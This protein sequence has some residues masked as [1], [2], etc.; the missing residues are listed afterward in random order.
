[1]EAAGA[2]RV[3]YLLHEGLRSRGHDAELWFLYFKRPAYSGKP[4]VRV[5]SN[6]RPSLASYLLLAIK[7]FVWIWNSK[8]DVIITHTHYAN[9]LGQLLGALAGVKTR[10]AVQHSILRK[11]PTFSR[12]ADWLLGTVGVYT[13]QIAVSHSVADSMSAY[14]ERYKRIVHTIYNGIALGENGCPNG[15]PLPNLPVGH[16]RILHVGRLS[17]EKNHE[18]LLKSLQQIPGA[19]LV[20]VGDGELRNTL[21]QRVQAMG[22]ADRVCFLGEIAPEEVRAVMNACDLFMFPSF[23]EALGMALLEA[24]A[25]GMPIVASDIPACREVLQDTGI[26][27]SPTPEELSRAAKGLL[28]DTSYAKEMGRKAA[29]RA[30][31]FSVDAMVD[32][33]EHLINIEMGA[34]LAKGQ[35]VPRH[36]RETI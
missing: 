4:G 21:E 15:Q 14:P 32:G 34:C 20:L 7:L 17:R 25:A 2:Q 16:P 35:G 12:H 19:Y 33:Y 8:P 22:L 29:E 24:M 6:R 36:A 3:A 26:L 11:Y 1:M 10:V 28:A 27:V 13:K 5:L 9:V 30:K 18:A 31:E 23:Y